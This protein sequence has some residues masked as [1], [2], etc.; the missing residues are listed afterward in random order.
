MDFRDNF[1]Q[2]LIARLER[3][4]KL[5]EFVTRKGE[6]IRVDW[7]AFCQ[8]ESDYA[9]RNDSIFEEILY[10]LQLKGVLTLEETGG[11]FIIGHGMDLS[12]ISGIGHYHFREKDEAQRYAKAKWGN[13]TYPVRIA[14]TVTDSVN[15]R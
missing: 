7:E 14:Q 10:Y 15:S 5:E 4:G 1:N 3:E 6:S 11:F 2:E 13:A 9:R 8:A 12:P